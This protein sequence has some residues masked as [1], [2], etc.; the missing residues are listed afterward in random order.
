MFPNAAP[1]G[2]V[3]EETRGRG[4]GQGEQR[5]YSST[6]QMMDVSDIPEVEWSNQNQKR[7]WR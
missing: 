4:H 3:E 7:F 1:T 2:T 6:Q 5:F